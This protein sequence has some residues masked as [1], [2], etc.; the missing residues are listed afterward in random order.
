M[1]RRERRC[2][3]SIVVECVVTA[4]GTALARAA[5]RAARRSLPQQLR[6]LGDIHRDPPRLILRWLLGWRCERLAFFHDIGDGELRR[7]VTVLGTSVRRFWRYG[8]TI[9]WL[10]RASGLTL[11]G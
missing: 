7:F 3:Y 9:A 5:G 8:E 6:Q 10:Q 1:H 4:A 11:Y 2:S